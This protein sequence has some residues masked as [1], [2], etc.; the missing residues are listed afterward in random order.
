[1][2]QA[3]RVEFNGHEVWPYANSITPH[4]PGLFYYLVAI[5]YQINH[6]GIGTMQHSGLVHPR[7]ESQYGQLVE[8]LLKLCRQRTPGQEGSKVV[9]FFNIVPNGEFRD[10]LD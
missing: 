7:H 3:E 4:Q 5:S 6:N 9:V 2:A 8:D 10:D 1:M